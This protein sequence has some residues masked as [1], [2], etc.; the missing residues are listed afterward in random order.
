MRTEPRLRSSNLARWIDIIREFAVIGRV[1]G[2]FAVKTACS[3]FDISVDSDSWYREFAVTSSSE[4]LLD[5][6]N[7]LR[8]HIEYIGEFLIEIGNH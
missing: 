1:G 3:G 8:P 4:E 6:K 2:G 5:S 7:S